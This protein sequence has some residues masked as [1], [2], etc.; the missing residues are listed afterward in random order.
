MVANSPVYW[1]DRNLKFHAYKRQRPAKNVQVLLDRIETSGD[2][3][4]WG[5]SRSLTVDIMED[6]LS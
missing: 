4:L 6:N 3:I 2:P 1:C 5:S